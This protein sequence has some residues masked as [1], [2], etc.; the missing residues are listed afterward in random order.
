[1]LK[2]LIVL[3]ML[4][5]FLFGKHLYFDY[6]TKD[7]VL[8]QALDDYQMLKYDEAEIKFKKVAQSGRELMDKGVAYK[9]LAF[10]AT[11]N[12]DTKK[13]ELYFGKLFE[14]YPDYEIDYNVV[15]PKISSFF[16]DY[17]EIWLR[18]P[19]NKIK[20]YPSVVNA[21]TYNNGIKLPMEWH[22]PNVEVG[23]VMIYY[24]SQGKRSAPY[25][26]ARFENIKID[27]NYT[28]HFPLSFLKEPQKSF[29]L[30]YFLV[31]SSYEGEKILRVGR[32]SA[33]LSIKVPVKIKKVVAVGKDTKTGVPKKDVKVT[34]TS[35]W[36]TSWWFI[37][38]V[39]VVVVGT[40]GGIYLLNQDS[41]SGGPSG[42]VLDIIVTDN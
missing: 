6:K 31:V 22:D 20:V 38:T 12:Q 28:A 11:L 35:S 29:T 4:P 40:V 39:S 9:H 21:I 13:A 26:T 32:K 17:H 14:I 16:K 37:T 25:S 24:R 41:S 5:A 15:T 10:M 2:Y 7:K 42:P 34:E 8:Q 27:K 18:M 3:L 19:H 36:Y 30:E 23:A 1:M 33:P